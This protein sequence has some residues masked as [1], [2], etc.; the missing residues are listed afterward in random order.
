MSVTWA[1]F[2]S[3]LA[4]CRWS[5]VRRRSNGWK[6]VRK[7]RRRRRKCRWSPGPW[8]G[9]E[10]T[11]YRATSPGLRTWSSLASPERCRSKE[12]PQQIQNSETAKTP[13]SGQNR[14]P[15]LCWDVILLI[16]GLEDAGG[17][18]VSRWQQNTR[19]FRIHRHLQPFLW[20]V[21]DS[22]EAVPTTTKKHIC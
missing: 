10:R 22:Q 4:H 9:V 2:P 21:R 8:T 11:A 14:P 3:L 15:L 19:V 16:S 1:V 18:G 7:R 5:D 6:H 12:T 20:K 13:G 17:P